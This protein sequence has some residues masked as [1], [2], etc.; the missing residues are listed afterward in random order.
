M[1]ES[2]PEIVCD[3]APAEV[4]RQLSLNLRAAVDGRSIRE[5]SR[6]TGV[7]RA[8]IGAILNGDAWPDLQT[9]ARLE[10]GFAR[11]LWPRFAAADSDQPE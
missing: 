6:L 9:I 11:P 3:D 4:A 7:D 8:S 10:I 1:S 2:W 5:V